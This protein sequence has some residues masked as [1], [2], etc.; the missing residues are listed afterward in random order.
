MKKP[1]RENFPVPEWRLEE[2]R[3]RFTC[4][5]SELEF[6]SI[7]FQIACSFDLAE[8]DR[9]LLTGKPGEAIQG[10]IERRSAA[11]SAARKQRTDEALAHIDFIKLYRRR[12]EESDFLKP[13][14]QKTV[15][16]NAKNAANAK[17]PRVKV[18]AAQIKEFAQS[19]G[20]PGIKFD[21][22]VHQ[23]KEK[24]CCSERTITRRW[25][26]GTK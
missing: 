7:F 2:G 15:D 4:G 5:N 11:I 26:E 1:E 25:E 23:A 14:A 10:L 12:L 8:F 9:W 18:T 13:L 24:F 6:A 17:L 19:I 16:I 20:Y 3:S 21:D 22:F